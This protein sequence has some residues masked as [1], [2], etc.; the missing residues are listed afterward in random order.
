MRNG[1]VSLPGPLAG[2]DDT[3]DGICWRL[4]IRTVRNAEIAAENELA[5]KRARHEKMQALMNRT[6]RR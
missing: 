2:L 3:R 1:Q 6:R 4:W 5:V